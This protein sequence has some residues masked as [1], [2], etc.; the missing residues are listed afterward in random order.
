MFFPYVILNKSASSWCGDLQAMSPF[1]SKVRLHMYLPK[2]YLPNRNWHGNS[3]EKFVSLD[4]LVLLG[5]ISV[6]EGL[7]VSERRKVERSKNKKVKEMTRS[8]ESKWIEDG[9][10]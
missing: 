5:N 10:N 1:I 3:A 4:M 8:R 6:E 2:G 9:E 7:G